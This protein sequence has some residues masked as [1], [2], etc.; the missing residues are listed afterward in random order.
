MA[1]MYIDG[2]MVD[3]SA[4]DTAIAHL[5]GLYGLT[6]DRTAEQIQAL[7]D[8]KSRKPRKKAAKLKASKRKIRAAVA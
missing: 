3:T 4:L 2:K 8:R 1:A 5:Q 7:E 6:L